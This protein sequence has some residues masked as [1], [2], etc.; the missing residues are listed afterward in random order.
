MALNEL[1]KLSTLFFIL[2]TCLSGQQKN[3]QINLETNA[4]TCSM[5]NNCKKDEYCDTYN[6]KKL[7]KGKFVCL[8]KLNHG[9][10]CNGADRECLS[11]NCYRWKCKGRQTGK[12]V[13]ANGSC[14]NKNHEDC[15]FEQYCKK[16][17]CINRKLKGWCWRDEECMSNHCS[18]TRKCLKFSKN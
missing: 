7:K 14:S 8:Q 16:N 1:L 6:F 9:E 12:D 10:A 4:T 18:I 13:P 2:L 17:K 5:Q 3:D 11:N 15:R